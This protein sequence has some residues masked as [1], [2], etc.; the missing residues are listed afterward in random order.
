VWNLQL[1]DGGPWIV[2]G[3]Y[4]VTMNSGGST[5]SQP[6]RVGMDPRIHVSDAALRKQY[7]FANQILATRELVKSLQQQSGARLKALRGGSASPATLEA[8]SALV[9]IAPPT[10]PNNSV[11][12][13][14]TDISSLRYLGN[15]LDGLEQTVESADTAP[16]LDA[17]TK[18]AHLRMLYVKN[19]AAWERLKAAK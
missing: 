17:Q 3:N 7:E 15:A 8:L 16:T 11:G 6:L 19:K 1:A 2:P 9:G 13:L 14:D 5:Y 4:T 18:Y 10:D 12:P